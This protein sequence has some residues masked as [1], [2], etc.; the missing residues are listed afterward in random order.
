VNQAEKNRI[1]M[2][3][4]KTAIDFLL[5]G[6]AVSFESQRPRRF[7]GGMILLGMTAAPLTAI[8]V[9]A[10]GIKWP[11][12]LA[13]FLVY[14]LIQAFLMSWFVGSLFQQHGMREFRIGIGAMLILTTMTA[15]PMG[16]ASIYRQLAMPEPVAEQI[17]GASPGKANREDLTFVVPIF[18]AIM[19]FSMI[20]LLMVCEAVLN[21]YLAFRKRH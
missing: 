21:W 2:T 4:T 13:T 20:P 18:A 16:T 8:S 19:Y 12:A 5:G 3:M 17:S 1:A 11:M 10:L 7:V 6:A 14:L 15:L 9:A